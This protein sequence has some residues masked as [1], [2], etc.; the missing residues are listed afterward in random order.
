MEGACTD[1]SAFPP[2]CAICLYLLGFVRKCKALQ[3]ALVLPDLPLSFLN[4][5]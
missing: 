3:E 2:L 4:N 5:K 1:L